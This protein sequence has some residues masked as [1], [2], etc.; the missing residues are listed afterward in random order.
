MGRAAQRDEDLISVPFPDEPGSVYMTEPEW[1]QFKIR[2]GESCALYWCERAEAY[3]EEYPR[4]WAK[5][6]NHFRT[7]GNW[8]QMKVS[9]GYEWFEHPT[10]G[11]GYYRSWVIDRVANGGR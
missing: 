5:Y 7:L 9:D 4:R 10:H 1:A 8:H 6:K 2:L 11:P 3:A